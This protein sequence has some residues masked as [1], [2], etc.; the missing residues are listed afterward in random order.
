MH[1][2][3]RITVKGTRYYKS[4]ELL[5]DGSLAPGVA[6]R[7]EHRPH[8]PHDSNAVAVC[9]KSTGAMLGYMPR[10][11]APKYA[12][13]VFGGKII[14]ATVSS[15]A[16]SDLTVKVLVIYEQSD[17]ELVRLHAS[18]LWFSASCGRLRL[19]A[20]R[21]RP[22]GVPRWRRCCASDARHAEHELTQLEGRIRR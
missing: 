18:R 20:A 8:N 15:I 5:K 3:A 19:T 10:D 11:L 22:L 7:L 6:I 21:A 9:V 1:V 12:A 14:S 17:E 13:L 16:K 4:A 2:S